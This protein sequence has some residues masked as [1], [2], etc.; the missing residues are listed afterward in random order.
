MT[1]ATIDLQKVGL[2]LQMKMMSDWEDGNAF[3]TLDFDEYLNY[4]Y[5]DHTEELIEYWKNPFYVVAEEQIEDEFDIVITPEQY[6]LATDGVDHLN[7]C[8]EDG[9]YVSM[10]GLREF[11][12][13]RGASEED[14]EIVCEI[15]AI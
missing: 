9:G 12:W 14:I 6:Q 4:D 15:I 8:F 13:E 7:A 1:Q 2:A 5:S 3:G 10:T 11:L